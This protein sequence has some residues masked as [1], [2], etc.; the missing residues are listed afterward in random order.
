[1]LVSSDQSLA[2]EHQ[3][4]PPGSNLSLSG[5][6]LARNAS[7][8][9]DLTTRPEADVIV[10]GKVIDEKGSA[11]PGVSVVVKGTTQ[12]TTTDG[13]GSFRISVPSANSVLVFSFVGYGSKEVVVGKQTN[14]T[15][16]LTP[17]DQTLNEVVVVGYGSQLKKEIT[18]AVQTVSAQEIKTFLFRRLVRNY[19]AVWPVCKST[20]LLVNRVR[21]L[22]PYSGSGICFG[23]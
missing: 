15:I 11:L 2:Q 1:M 10:T 3:T 20:R 4:P 8:K 14:L 23:W 19:K 22:D 16:T 13:T 5:Q 6:V 18:G 17:D 7:G 21:V 12:G 9:V